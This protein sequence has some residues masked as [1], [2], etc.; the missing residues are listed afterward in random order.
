MKRRA[1]IRVLGLLLA[2]LFIAPVF[3]LPARADDYDP[4]Y[5]ENLAEGHLSAGAAILIEAE[6]GRVIF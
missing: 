4:L 3:A 6:T 5:P 1:M 2:V